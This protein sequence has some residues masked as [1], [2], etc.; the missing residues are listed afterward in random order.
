MAGQTAMVVWRDGVPVSTRF[1]DP[2]YSTD[3]GLAESRHVFLGGNR[4]RERLRPG[5]HVAELGIG[6]GLNLLTLMALVR[7]TGC[8]PVRYT[9]FEAFPMCAEDMNSALS[10]FAE[11][12]EDA[13]ELVRAWR[14]RRRLASPAV[15][16]EFVIG[17]AR[18]TLPRWQGLADAWFLDGFAPARNPEL[19]EPALLQEVA[20]HTARTGTAAT[21]SAAG[22]V[23]RALADAGFEVARLPGYG[24]KRHMT[25]ARLP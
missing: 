23:R 5:F 4:L 24:R 14:D 25:T 11:L 15:V 12:R 21:Y 6:T 13:A 9:G 8:G 1:D 19:W 16:A 22:E 20:R 17:D 2:Y 10:A 3:D 7:E 18:E